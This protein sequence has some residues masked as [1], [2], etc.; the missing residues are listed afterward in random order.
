MRAILLIAIALL[1]GCKNTKDPTLSC[2]NCIKSHSELRM[3][4]MP[5]THY[6][7]KSCFYTTVT[8]MWLPTNVCDQHIR[9]TYPNPNYKAGP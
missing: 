9:F 8:P 6:C 1:A 5:M 2:V 4:M 3:V 7:G